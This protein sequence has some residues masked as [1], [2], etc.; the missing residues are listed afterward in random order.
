MQKEGLHKINVPS[1]DG[2]SFVFATKTNFTNT[3]K[4][5]FIIH[6]AGAVRAGQW[7]RSLI[8]NHS[9]DHGTVLPYIKRAKESGY[10]VIVTNTNY[11]YGIVNGE[12]VRFEGNGSPEEHINTV[13]N[14]LIEPAIDTI[15][16]F[17]VVA[18]SYGGVVTL[19]MASNHPDAF[20]N[21]CFGIAFTDS[22][23]YEGGLSNKMRA[24]FHEVKF[25]FNDFHR[26][27]QL[28]NV[29]DFWS[30]FFLTLNEPLY[31]FRMLGILS[32]HRNH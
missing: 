7:T 19:V 4:L 15:E 10:D 29:D 20:L 5:L 12:R 23:H 8:I 16:A 1:P 2:Q 9:L 17:G 13:W 27:N 14:E 30:R 11:N 31:H 6:G 22:V 32:L 24:W 28:I 25:R 26:M 3:K 21:K 18:H